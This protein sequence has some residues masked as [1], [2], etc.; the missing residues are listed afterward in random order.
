MGRWCLSL[1]ALV[2]AILLFAGTAFWGA[3]VV[4]VCALL[5]WVPSVLVM[6]RLAG[7]PAARDFSGVFGATVGFVAAYASYSSRSPKPSLVGFLL[8]PV[9]GLGFGYGLALVFTIVGYYCNRWRVI[10]PRDQKP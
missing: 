9:I 7:V 10:S 5:L 1:C 3:D 2:I 4:V 8:L 6:Y